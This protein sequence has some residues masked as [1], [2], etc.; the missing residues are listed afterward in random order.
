MAQYAPHAAHQ[1][2]RDDG[3]RRRHRGGDATARGARRHIIRAQ[4]R[5]ST[6]FSTEKRRGVKSSGSPV[7]GTNPGCPYAQAPAQARGGGGGGGGGG[8]RASRITHVNSHAH[9]CQPRPDP[10][11]LS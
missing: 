8:G 11:F 1:L 9:V 7:E 3:V 4:Y 10:R 2:T 5:L 6:H